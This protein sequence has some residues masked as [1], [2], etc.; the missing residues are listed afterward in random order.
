GDKKRPYK[1]PELL[2]FGTLQQ[3]SKGLFGQN[4]II[5]PLL[6]DY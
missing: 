1:K 2:K 3:L 6:G 5:T 4:G